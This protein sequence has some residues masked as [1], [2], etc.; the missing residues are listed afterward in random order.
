MYDR[1]STITPFDS[2]VTEIRNCVIKGWGGFLGHGDYDQ[3][4]NKSGSS[5][6]ILIFLR[7][8][9]FRRFSTFS[10]F[11][12]IFATEVGRLGGRAQSVDR[13]LGSI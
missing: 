11:G 4:T 1:K 3:K 9:T 10:C 6:R 12:R 2:L 7:N 13:C 8:R 5:A